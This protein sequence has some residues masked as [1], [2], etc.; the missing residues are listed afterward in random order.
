MTFNI[1]A[2][3]KR[4]RRGR[5]ITQEELSTLLGVSPQSVS[6]W[7]RGDCYPDTELLPKIA[8]YFEVT[9][10]ELFGMS[11]Q[12]EAERI[13]DALYTEGDGRFIARSPEELFTSLERWREI[14]GD[15]PHNDLAQL[16]YASRL[17]TAESLDGAEQDRKNKRLAIALL[18]KV[19][20]RS[21][22]SAIR[23]EAESMLVRAYS[24]AGETRKARELVKNLP[25]AYQTTENAYCYLSV[26]DKNFRE[27]TDKDQIK[28]MLL[29]SAFNLTLSL[30]GLLSALD[31][32]FTVGLPRVDYGL[33]KKWRAVKDATT[34]VIK[35]IQEEEK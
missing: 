34:E 29:S 5:D 8:Y 4:L 20:G 2:N 23:N 22:D 18:E 19:L 6:N 24:S 35:S 16:R 3:L 28:A 31:G 9:L 25:N 27:Q 17:T 32:T 11:N 15:Y 26:F 33:P 30:N 10:D 13:A 21:T 12:R 7:E 1:G 14:A